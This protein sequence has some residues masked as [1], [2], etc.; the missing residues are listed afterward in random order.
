MNTPPI[1]TD[2]PPDVAAALAGMAQQI[3]ELTATLADIHSTACIALSD[4]LSDGQ[5]LMWASVR[6]AANDAVG[7]ARRQQ[8]KTGGRVVI[9]ERDGTTIYELVQ[10]GYRDG[11]PVYVNRW[12]ATIQPFPGK[13][14][15]VHAEKVATLLQYAPALLAALIELYDATTDGDRYKIIAARATARRAMSQAEPPQQGEVK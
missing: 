7:Q 1:P 15:T 6:A 11:N 12:V 14:L 13:A 5:R 4:Q 9:I 2:T 3:E 8:Q 10:D